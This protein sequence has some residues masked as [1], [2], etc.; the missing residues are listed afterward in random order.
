MTLS[1]LIYSVPD[2]IPGLSNSNSSRREIG[3]P[4]VTQLGRTKS[5]SSVYKTWNNNNVGHEMKYDDY[6]RY[7]IKWYNLYIF[8][9]I[10]IMFVRFC[11]SNNRTLPNGI[12]REQDWIKWHEI[13]LSFRS[14]YNYYYQYYII[15]ISLFWII[16]LNFYPSV[17]VSTTGKT[18]RIRVTLE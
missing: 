16:C 9:F 13:F 8:I 2:S 4:W 7:I 10:N 5:A 14:S 3:P 17:D 15:I 6:S 18:N 12:E 11:L 1:A